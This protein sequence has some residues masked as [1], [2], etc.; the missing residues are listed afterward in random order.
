MGQQRTTPSN[1]LKMKA[2]AFILALAVLAP[3]TAWAGPP[4]I[5]DDPETVEYQHGEFYIAS[6]YANNKDSKEGTA[7]HFEFN[8]GIIPDVQLHLLVPLAFV[9]PNGGPTMYGFGDTEVGVKY[10]FLHETDSVPQVGTFP[11]VHLPTGDS[12]RAVGGHVP[13][14]L[15]IWLQKSRGPW[16]TYGGGG[17]WINPGEGNKNFWQLSWLGQREITKSLTLGAEI[18]YFGKDTDDGRDRTGY[19]IGWIFNLSEDHHILFSAGSDIAGN[20]RFSAYLGYQ[21]TF[22]PR[23]AEKK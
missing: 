7:P 18:F 11:I 19:N 6:Q 3:A 23:E 9:H 21:Y 20:N 17:Y 15:P 16:T 14:F 22:G 8:Y 5:T 13:V 2:L 12:D 10:R 1:R 4:F